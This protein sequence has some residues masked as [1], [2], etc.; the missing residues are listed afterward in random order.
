MQKMHST[1]AINLS[2]FLGKLGLIYPKEVAEGIDHSI[3]KIC[4]GFCFG[5]S[6][7]EDLHPAFKGLIRMVKTCPQMLLPVYFI[8][9]QRTYHFISKQLQ[10]IKTL[11][12]KLMINSCLS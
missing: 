2:I 6:G 9:I 5:N 1:L 8:I 3:K 7:A 12:L 4:V 10:S 11:H